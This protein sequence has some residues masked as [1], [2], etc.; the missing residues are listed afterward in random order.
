[1]KEFGTTNSAVA[2]A[3]WSISVWNVC[4]SKKHTVRGVCLGV[5][6]YVCMCVCV[7]VYYMR[8]GA[9]T[10]VILLW[11]IL[12]Y[13]MGTQLQHGLAHTH[14]FRYIQIHTNKNTQKHNY[15]I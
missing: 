12:D 5:C 8:L 1:M 9:E 3:M 15:V 11:I 13:R 6:I 10:A 7:C 14:R 2:S 4:V